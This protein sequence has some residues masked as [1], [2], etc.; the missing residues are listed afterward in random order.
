MV[1]GFF[2]EEKVY[3]FI[4]VGGQCETRCARGHATDNTQVGLQVTASQVVWQKTP[5]F[6]FS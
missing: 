6:P 1:L 5:I 2:E 3:D 4:I